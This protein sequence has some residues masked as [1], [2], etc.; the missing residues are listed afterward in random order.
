MTDAPS[1]EGEESPPGE[2][3]S[4]EAVGSGEAE[5]ER[6]HGALVLRSHGQEVLHPTLNS[7]LEVIS[8]LQ[9][10]GF[11]LCADVSSVD[12]LERPARDLPPGIEPERFEL[13]VNLVS[14]DPPARVRIRVQV[15]ETDPTVPTLFTFYPGSEAMEREVFDLMGIRF[16]GHPD[17]TRI[18]MPEDW[19]GH[20]LRKDY[21]IGSIPVQFKAAPSSR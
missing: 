7:Y 8:D 11:I 12:Y 13:V 4:G 17:M 9:N 19:E 14:M 18:L 20:P 6:R 15:P 2:A 21:A 5:P 10:E 16:D 3:A 1:G